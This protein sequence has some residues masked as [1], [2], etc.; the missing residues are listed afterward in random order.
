MNRLRTKFALLLVVAI[1]AVVGLMTVV[2]IYVLGPSKPR[3]GIEPVADQVEM[4]AK[5][6]TNKDGAVSLHPEPSPGVLYE[7]STENL[8]AALKAR[9]ID[10]DVAVSRKSREAP[11]SRW[12]KVG[13][14]CRC[15]T[16]PCSGRLGRASSNGSR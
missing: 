8:R 11:L 9:N 16:C 1:V 7:R 13:C 3:H 10:F 4:L 5:L 15:R 2:M 14:G 12:I 6:A